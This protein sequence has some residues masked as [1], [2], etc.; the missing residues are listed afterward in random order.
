MERLSNCQGVEHLPELLMLQEPWQGAAGCFTYNT[1]RRITQPRHTG[2]V[3]PTLLCCILRR[4]PG[5]TQSYEGSG[6]SS[7]FTLTTWCPDLPVALLQEELSELLWKRGAV[8]RPGLV[9]GST[10]QK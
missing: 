8:K 6:I 9:A 1:S 10:E 2:N 7:N 3:V 5:S 4:F